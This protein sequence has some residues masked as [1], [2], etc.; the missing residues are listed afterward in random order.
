MHESTKCTSSKTRH[1]DL[2]DV[3]EGQNGVKIGVEVVEEVDHLHGRAA[4]RQRGEADDVGEVDGDRFVGLWVHD[5]ACLQ[6]L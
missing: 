1:T 4:R 3:M 5:V 2:V 6:L